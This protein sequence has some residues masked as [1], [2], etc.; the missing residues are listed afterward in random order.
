MGSHQSSMDLSCA[1]ETK[2]RHLFRILGK[3]LRRTYDMKKTILWK[4]RPSFLLSCTSS[5]DSGGC[6]SILHQQL[7]IALFIRRHCASVFVFPSSLEASLPREDASAQ[8]NKRGEGQHRSLI[9]IYFILFQSPTSPSRSTIIPF[10][11]LEKGLAF[12]FLR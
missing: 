5:T 12:S 6:L 8:N 4:R 3:F 1:E 7:T 10:R 11:L 9:V 2:N